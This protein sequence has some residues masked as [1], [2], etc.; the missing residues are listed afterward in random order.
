[1]RQQGC[2]EV[3][4]FGSSSQAVIKN[5]VIKKKMLNNICICTYIY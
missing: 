5:I 4:G 2:C 3:T 1:M